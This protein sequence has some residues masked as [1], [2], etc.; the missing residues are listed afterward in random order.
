MSITINSTAITI[1]SETLTFEDIYQYA[2]TT[3]RTTYIQKLGTSYN[4][5]VDLILKNN[6][7]LSDTNKFITVEGD[8]FQIEKGSSLKLGERRLDESTYDGCTLNIPNVKLGYGFGSTNVNNSGDLFLYN[9][10]IN[11][12]GFWG[13]FEGNNHVEIINCFI[14]GFGRISGSNSIIKNVIYKR[15]HG[16]Y[17]LM[18]PKGNIRKMINM[19]VYDSF[20]YNNL[21]CSVYHNPKFAPDLD[22]FYGEYSGYDKLAY[23]EPTTAPHRL[24]M[25]GSK[26]NGNYDIV[27]ADN[28]VD[29]YH[30]F[31]FNPTI[32]DNNGNEVMSVRVVIKDKNGDIVFD[33]TTDNNGE[34]DTWVTYYRDIAGGST[35][36]LTPHT[37]EVSYDTYFNT[38]ELFINKNYEKFP[39]YLS[40]NNSTSTGGDI[41]YDRIANMLD[42]VKSEIIDETK[43]TSTKFEILL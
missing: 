26:I 23:I 14:D 34:I 21:R 3:N 11:I 15:S 30:K 19:S 4:I 1:D 8:L 17:G 7:H 9:S 2:V 39:L 5:K 35:D 24:T 27:R 32:L 40:N 38:L 29:F 31:R 37:I 10:T 12:F 28:N 33:N 18:S 43:D 42:S 36:V 22:I 16:R 41:D 6:S 25:H 20:E 13:F